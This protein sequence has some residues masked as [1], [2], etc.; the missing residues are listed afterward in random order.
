MTT[1]KELLGEHRGPIWV[2]SPDDTVY[3]A[4][5]VMADK[6]IGALPVIGPEGL[7][8]ILT[9]R[10]YARRGILL[11][12]T[13]SG[14][15]VRD[16]MTTSLYRVQ[17][18]DT[19]ETCEALMT[20]KHVRH[21]PVVDAEGQFVGLLSIRDVLKAIIREQQQHIAKLSL[22]ETGHTGGG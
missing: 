7:V 2:I 13:S 11:G 3:H 16:L 4:L 14:T 21:L 1:V 19:L 15:L 9:E 5:E 18:D 17:P 6:D 10:D 20:N 12:H 8:G 22:R